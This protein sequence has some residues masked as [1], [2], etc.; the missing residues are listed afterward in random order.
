MI[1]VKGKLIKLLPELKG[2]NKKTGNEW[3]KQD[4][5]INTGE[6]YNPEICISAFREHIETINNIPVNSYIEVAI[7]L[8]SKNYQENKYFHNITAWK[9]EKV[10]GLEGIE[11]LSNDP[12]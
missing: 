3:K 6:E 2:I 9:I 8:Y 10:D 11:N 12:F 7:N 5:I 1:K 4:F